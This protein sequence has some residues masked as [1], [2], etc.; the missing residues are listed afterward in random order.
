M[1]IWYG[2]ADE[3]AGQYADIL[4]AEITHAERRP[5]TGSHIPP[6]NAYRDL[7]RWLKLT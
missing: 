7:L 4:A 5:Y 2:S 3:R 1:S 6:V